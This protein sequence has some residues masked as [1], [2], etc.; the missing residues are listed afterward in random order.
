MT[1]IDDRTVPGFRA[2][3]TQLARRSRLLEVAIRRMR[4]SAIE[5]RRADIADVHTLRLLVG[6]ID[7]EMV[8]AEA[9]AIAADPAKRANLSL[10][11]ELLDAGTVEV[12][13]AGLCTWAPDFSVFHHSRGPHHVLIGPHAF[14]K[15]ARP[16]SLLMASLHG[17]RAAQRASARFAELWADG[18]DVRPAV[19]E[20][21][22]RAAVRRNAVRDVPGSAYRLGPSA[23]QAGPAQEP[24]PYR[25]GT[26]ADAAA[27]ALACAFGA[28]RTESA[29]QGQA[30]G[31]PA[32]ESHAPADCAP[33]PRPNPDL[34]AYQR[35]AAERAAHILARRGGVLIC[36]SVGLGKTFIAL[37]LVEDALRRGGRVAV[38]S[39]AA[40]RP[41]WT[42]PLSALARRVGVRHTIGV[43][44]GR[45][46]EPEEGDGA[47]T[48]GPR[49]QTGHLELADA[50][51]SY[52]PL[53]AWLSQGRLSRGTHAPE[54]LR[55]LDLLVVDE[56]HNFRNPATRRYAALAQ[57]AAGARIA[58]LT[59]TPVN[60][61]AWDLYWL[62]RLFVGDGD[63]ADLGIP[64]L[65][66]AVNGAD[67]AGA[68]L[69]PVVAA[70]S[71]RRS[72]TFI[73]DH[74]GS[75]GPAAAGAG[76][77]AL[78]FPTR[79]PPLPIRYSLEEVRPGWYGQAL[80]ILEELEFAALEA[81]ALSHA[82]RGPRAQRR[83]TRQ[84]APRQGRQRHHGRAQ[85]AAPAELLRLSL[86]KRLESSAFAFAVSIARHIRMAETVRAALAAG[87]LPG[88]RELRALAAADQTGQ[89]LLAPVIG[90]PL[91]RGGDARA[92]ADAIERDLE[93]LRRLENLAHSIG[94]DT[95][96]KLAR[97]LQLV[98][99]EIAGQKVAVFTEFRDTARYL[100]RALAGFVRAAL[101]DGQ[102]A[103]VGQAPASRR[104]VIARFAP[105]ANGAPPP[106][107]AERI[108]VLVATDVLSEGLNLQ[109]AARVVSYDLPWNPVRIIQRVG[110][111]DR[112]GSPHA[113]VYA[114]HFLP[115]T[116]LEA[117]LR[118]HAR[119]RAKLAAIGQT[120]GTD[121]LI[122][123]DEAPV[124]LDAVLDALA[125]GDSACLE[126]IERA[127]ATP[128][129]VEERIR[130]RWKEWCRKAALAARPVPTAP[131]STG[132]RHAAGD[133]SSD[134]ATTAAPGAAPAATARPW[135][136][137]R[138]PGR[139]VVLGPAAAKPG[140][141]RP[142]TR[143]PTPWVAAAVAKDRALAGVTALCFLLEKPTEGPAPD[144]PGP[145]AGRHPSTIGAAQPTPAG[146]LPA[147][148]APHDCWI[149]ADP[150]GVR[151]DRITALRAFAS[152]LEADAAPLHG[153]R[154]HHALHA[155]RA[156]L[157]CSGP[158]PLDPRSPEAR[159]LRR[160]DR[161]LARVRGEPD[162]ELCARIDRVARALARP[163]PAG[164]HRA[165][166]RAL[167]TTAELAPFLAA[168][169]EILA[170]ALPPGEPKPLAHGSATN[171][172]WQLLAAIQFS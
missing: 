163:L 34:T 74:Y 127:E 5:L 129:E 114:Y 20:I 48:Q 81:T 54:R 118:L 169:E 95:D 2:T 78:R 33:A 6:P 134:N 168:V 166:A 83:W 159:A 88:A 133:P 162:P 126:R 14:Q 105:Q 77:Q 73:R 115:D 145:P 124:P 155:A 10:I 109:D 117:L 157:E 27:L 79:A 68:S 59:A 131:A 140:P 40:L 132:P 1:L 146:K 47:G 113:L 46:S 172:R 160:L 91:P 165:L 137:N 23:A 156:L 106:R 57:L 130:L 101:V 128:F 55:P 66:E 107:P 84:A 164:P 64:S 18:R 139:T 99:R 98:T 135:A 125:R 21:L 32:G 167:D 72:R 49:W 22:E 151:L 12:R 93:R 45:G 121:G 144:P 51:R 17:A 116:G 102:H 148:P 60:N 29:G 25:E 149:V 170:H 154:L 112:L 58:L 100:H 24:L 13:A 152:A 36:D 16:G 141:W 43:R 80:R 82:G 150:G 136:G 28:P 111:I 87:R 30:P 143:D 62:L 4:L 147:M 69:Q 122:L 19:L 120:V 171:Q 76:P 104:E 31:A 103:R 65:K 8:A 92:L 44:G 37:R 161:G 15:P 89:L 110:R 153:L 42:G 41:Q 11:I 67:R 50:R 7:T 61:S 96:P 138:Q 39:P 26:P 75:D 90:E 86:L 9:Q 70:L 52:G 71:V 123:G 94:P 108:D 142:L 97:L 85:A 35:D 56:A 38:I 3:F 53:L 119:I 158:A 63:L